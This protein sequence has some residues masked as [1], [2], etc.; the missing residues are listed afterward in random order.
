M[1]ILMGL[2]QHR[3]QITTDWVDTA[4]G[5]VSRA[6]VA[7][8]DR[9]GVRRF[10]ARFRGQALEVALEATTGWRFV[11]EELYRIGAIVHLAEPADTAALRGSKKRA[12][13]D[14][15]DARHL[16]ELLMAGR[17][18]ESWIAPAHILDL[19]ARVRLRHTLSA[20]RGEWQ[21]RIQSVLYHHGCPKRGDLINRAGLTW[22]ATLPLAASAREQ[23]TVALA[24]IDALERQLAPLDK[25]LRTYARRQPGCKALQAHRN[26]AA[27]VGHDPGRARRPEPLLLLHTS[28]PVLRAGHHRARLRP[29]PRARPPLPPGTASVALGAVRSRPMRPPA[30]L[31]RPRLLPAG[32]GAARWQPRLPVDRAQ[33]AQAQ[34]PHAAPARRGGPATRMT[35]PV[36]AKPSFTQMRRG[37]LPPSSRRHP[38]VDG[39]HRPSGRNASPSGITPS[40]IMSPTRKHP[41]SWTEIRL[42][43]RAHHNPRPDLAR[44]PPNHPAVQPS[45]PESHL[46]SD[47]C[48][49]K[50]QQGGGR[51][52]H[53]GSHRALGLPTLAEDGS[54]IDAWYGVRARDTTVKIAFALPYG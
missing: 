42:G 12:K 19:R 50:E 24:M 54:V 48:T 36:R 23:I 51:I 38:H 15:A 5:E 13:N 37:Q 25:Q 6:R 32:G 43:A 21:Q 17:V 9:V 4:T 18:P 34:L 26:R 49:D 16:R 31:T 1:A 3:A 44:A 35:S 14:R 45:N 2:D 7:P 53:S 11:V 10:F 8:A 27:N 39:H 47:A 40:T 28:R 20:Q 22:L 33:T 41:G 30:K 52:V 29:A 46:T